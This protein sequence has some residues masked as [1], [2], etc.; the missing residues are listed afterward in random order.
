MTTFEV[1]REYHADG[2][3]V[4]VVMLCG[5]GSF[6]VMGIGGLDIVCAEDWEA[7]L[8][9]LIYPQFRFS[10]EAQILRDWAR[11]AL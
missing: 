3:A 6:K 8:R 7:T 5:E 9:A 4:H 11:D 1:V 10:T 2:I